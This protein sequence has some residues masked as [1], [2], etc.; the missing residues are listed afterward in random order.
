M[1][2]RLFPSF[3]IAACFMLLFLGAARAEMQSTAIKFSDPAKPG[4]LKLRLGHGDLQLTGVVSET[5]E[6]TVNSAGQPAQAPAR[7]DGLRVIT[8]ASSYILTES[9]NVITLDTTQSWGARNTGDFTVTVPRQT[10]VIITSGWGGEIACRDLSG[11]IEIRGVN[12]EVKL[13]DL[14][15]GAVVESMNGDITARF[16][17][18][19]EGRPLSF[20]SMNG[21]V[22]LH[23][24]AA[25]KANVRL[26]TQNGT[27][28]TDFDESALVTKTETAPSSSKSRHPTVIVTRNKSADSAAES[29]R[30]DEIRTAVRDAIQAGAEAAREAAVAIREAAQAAREGAQ[31]ARESA[32]AVSGH[33]AP[34]V[35]PLPPMTGGKIVSG[36]LNGGGPDI[37]VTT[38]NGD[39][40]LR[41]VDAK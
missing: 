22:V 35:P 15:G 36:T 14:A 34:P 16:A 8:A 7:K 37:R 23:L 24:P 25:A 4:T 12:G 5:G 39:V 11:D 10:N 18:V 28:L 38:M 41:K 30:N 20:T 27:I 33:P 2:S 26:R 21:E 29:A 31:A 3:V 32:T 17:E 13:T 40:T 1:K 6:I 19:R 9:A